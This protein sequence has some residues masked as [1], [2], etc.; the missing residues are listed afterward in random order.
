[1]LSILSATLIRVQVTKAQSIVPQI[2]DVMVAPMMIEK[3]R[4][5]TTTMSEPERSMA[6]AEICRLMP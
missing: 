5:V 6:G 2:G 4:D 1:M 3:L